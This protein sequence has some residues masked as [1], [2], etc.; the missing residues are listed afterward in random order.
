MRPKK[1]DTDHLVTYT[2][3]GKMR[4]P[5]MGDY[6]PAL[7]KLVPRQQKFVLA[8]LAGGGQNAT[9]AYCD[10]GYGGNRDT[11][12]VNSYKLLHDEKVVAAIVEESRKA[13][14]ADT[15]YA[16]HVVREVLDSP[17][18]A[19]KDRLRAAEMILNRGGLHATSEHKVSV[20]HKM[21]H[22]QLVAKLKLLAADCGLDA[23]KLLRQ[24]GVQAVEA[25]FTEVPLIEVDQTVGMEGLEDMF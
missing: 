2:P 12:K 22:G 16:R 21:D 14:A 8:Y 25:D 19:A 11:A 6:G 20:E 3:H 13:V 5:D 15:P 18:L 4:L 9:Q 7:R 10:A 24:A 23:D 1:W 17:H